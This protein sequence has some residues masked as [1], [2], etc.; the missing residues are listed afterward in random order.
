MTKKLNPKV[1]IIVPVYNTADYLSACL[2]SLLAQTYE[3]LEIII[4]D[5]G[6]TDNSPAIIESYAKKDSRIKTIRQKNQG[7]S[8]ARNA[9]LKE[10]TGEYVTFVDSDDM[11]E[12]SMLQDMI[13]AL[14]DTNSDIAVCSFKEI[15]PNGKI[16]HF[17]KN[18]PKKVYDTKSALKAMLQ[19]RGFMIS[20]TM[21]LF[22]T[23]YFKDIKFPVGKLH[24]D[25]GTTY[26]LIQKAR[27]II[28]LP[29]E[30][31]LYCHYGDSIIS[32][33]NDHKLDLINLTD[34]MCDEIDTKFS[35]L[36]NIT[37]ERRMRAR[38]SIL[39]QIPLDHP[40]TKSIIKYLRDHQNYITDN[41]KATKT[42][43]IALK[44]AL[45]NPKLFQIA[46][47]L[48]K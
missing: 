34:K 48:F 33:F 44:F 14:E 37:N 30:C 10:A 35:D 16:V 41:P 39:R 25:V 20:T 4:I 19:E 22:P 6:S 3:N 24:E 32:K 46:Y 13:I 15:Y 29:Q 45:F 9:G 11:I 47:K 18:L 38:F 23:K 17:N 5:D 40:E 31:Y 27:N 21:K 26:K 1:S 28:F 8:G 43:K 12:P 36:K 7:L 42:D 2:D